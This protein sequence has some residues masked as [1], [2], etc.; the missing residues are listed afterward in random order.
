M[1]DHFVILLLSLLTLGRSQ[2]VQEDTDPRLAEGEKKMSDSILEMLEHF[3]QPDPVGIPGANIPD[4]YPVPDMK[5]SLAFGTVLYFKNSSVYG[6]SKFRILYINAEIG[7][8]EVQA[9]LTID[10]LQAR[11]NYTMSTWLNKAQGPYTVD[12]GGLKVNAKANLGVERDGKLRAQ[13]IN[14]DIGFSNITVDFQNLGL[15][16]S[17]FQ[18]VINSIGP[19][20]FESIKPYIL[21]EAYTKARAEINSKLDEVAGDMQFPNSISPLDMIIADARKKV[22][23][24]QMDPYKVKD[25]NAS[26]SIFSITLSNTWVTGISSFQRVGNITLKMENNA[27]IADFD[28][29]TQ[30][31]EGMTQWEITALSGVMSRA[32]TASFSVEYISGRLILAQPLDT[33]ERPEFRDLDLEVGNIQVRCNGAGTL[34]Y[35]IEAGV[36]ILP[37]LLRYQIMDALEGPL[38]ERIQQELDKINVEETIKQEL[39]KVDEMQE[40]GFKLSS[41]KTNE[42]THEPYDEDE[43]FNF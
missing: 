10:K 42:V 6:I 34:D 12:V 33:R 29:G 8:M 7:A 2:D 17:V 41:L 40:Q 35:V 16:G 22:Q 18:G 11:G 1:R 14:I 25:Y 31:L 15:M 4:P 28:I 9:V 43:F 36:N 39:H 5:Q 26:V 38:K 37:N 3:K 19:F 32:G 24:M 27:V 30:K 20:V 21:K 23:A 13:N